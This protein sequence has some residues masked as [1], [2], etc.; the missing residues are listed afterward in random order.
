MQ[1]IYRIIEKVAPSDASILIHGES[2]TG[3]E[4]IAQAIHAN[5]VRAEDR[6]VPVDCVALPENLME[7]ELFGHE[8]GALYRCWFTQS[9]AARRCR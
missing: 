8:K 6:F 4:L 7:S 9:R 2:G 1:K 3:K 5:S